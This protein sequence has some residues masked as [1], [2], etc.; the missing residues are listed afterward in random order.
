MPGNEDL[1]QNLLRLVEAGIVGHRIRHNMGVK[2][3]Q[4]LGEGA[5]EGE[6]G[7]PAAFKLDHF[8]GIFMVLA[9]GMG[10]AA[11][12]MGWEARMDKG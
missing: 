4:E 7:G 9:A 8:Q 3:L 5:S 6:G 1:A 10:V 12:V 11:M 2:Y